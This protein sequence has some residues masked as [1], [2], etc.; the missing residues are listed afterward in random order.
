MTTHTTPAA[1]ATAFPEGFLW[2]AST[3]AYQVE[4]AW[5]A[6]GKG[7]SVIDVRPS[8]PEDTTDYKVAADHYHRYAEDVELFGQ[9]GLRRTVLDRLDPIIPDGDPVECRGSP[10]ST[11]S[12]T[13]CSRWALSRS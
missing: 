4:G 12:S 7:P 3:S 2:G 10:S 1:Q 5:D 8:Y 6:D 9:I 13:R 11:V